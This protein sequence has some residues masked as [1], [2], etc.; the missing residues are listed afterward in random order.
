M[1]AHNA[2]TVR[3]E[4]K[5]ISRLWWPGYVS[6]GHPDRVARLA[7]DRGQGTQVHRSP[8]YYTLVDGWQTWD[9]DA[10]IGFPSHWAQ[11]DGGRDDD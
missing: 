1:S 6:I 2:E 4:R 10:A 8:G 5:V 9:W 11:F 7:E 3:R